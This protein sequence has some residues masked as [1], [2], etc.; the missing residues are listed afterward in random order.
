MNYESPAVEIVGQASELIQ[1]FYGP[2]IDGGGTSFSQGAIC[3][4]LEE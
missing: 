1:T 3:S 4:E 2:R